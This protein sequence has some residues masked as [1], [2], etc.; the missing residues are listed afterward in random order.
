[1]ASVSSK[2]RT[3]IPLAGLTVLEILTALLNIWFFL[4]SGF[5]ILKP[6]TIASEDFKT[7]LV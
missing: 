5:S 4:I 6:L 2:S 7:S 1:M 3:V